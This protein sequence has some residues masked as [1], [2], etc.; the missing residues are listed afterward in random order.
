MNHNRE[1]QTILT[2]F[3]LTLL[4]ISIV[5]FIYYDKIGTMENQINE[6]VSKHHIK[7]KYA[8]E[9]SNAVRHRQTTLL[10]T[11]ALPNFTDN[12]EAR[13]AFHADAGNFLTPYKKL[14]DLPMSD[15]EAGLIT[16]IDEA[17]QM[18]NTIQNSYLEKIKSGGHNSSH[19]ILLN[20]SIEAQNQVLKQVTRLTEY[21]NTS[22]AL[23]ET[24]TDNAIKH[25]RTI[26]ISLGIFTLLIVA[27]IAIYVL[28]K[29]TSQTR[30]IQE[31][32]SLPKDNP[33]PVLRLSTTGL[34]IFANE[35]G[36]KLLSETGLKI[37]EYAPDYWRNTIRSMKFNDDENNSRFEIESGKH[38]YS[39]I[40]THVP[41]Q[42][43]V[44]LYGYDITDIELSKKKMQDLTDSIE[45]IAKLPSEN[46]SPVLRMQPDGKITFCNKAGE[47]ILQDW[48]CKVGEYAPV[49]WH[50]TVKTIIAD[51]KDYLVYE[52][53][54]GK[55]FSF[56]VV[57]G[58]HGD[59]INLFGHDVTKVNEALSISSQNH[60]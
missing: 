54:S 12:K 20:K 8:F 29:N 30:K 5:V 40:V 31:L 41:E 51:G 42:G 48:Q 16:S 32:A 17:A 10:K 53:L 6:M 36:K 45:S 14:K 58:E 25:T 11:A 35:A 23:A 60:A 13:L 37:N 33:S 38:S 46:P 24:K 26:V 4:L 3:I 28:R 15:S 18:A 27:L 59:Y 7:L 50:Q 19:E 47:L 1:Q 49:Y 9:I 22:S 34:I 39:F 43:Y 55:K 21:Y 2:G 52:C 44:N 57:S 56:N